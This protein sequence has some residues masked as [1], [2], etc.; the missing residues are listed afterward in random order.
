M[1]QLKV[2]FFGLICH[3]GKNR[4]KPQGDHAVLVNS[5]GHKP[6]LQWKHKNDKPNDPPRRACLEL[7]GKDIF[8]GSLRRRP[9]P[10]APSFQK[11]VVKLNDLILSGKSV[12]NNVRQQNN[13]DDVHAYIVYPAEADNLR[14]VLLYPNI[15]LHETDKGVP[16][17]RGCVA[18][19]TMTTFRTDKDEKEVCIG[20]VKNKKWVDLAKVPADGCVLFSNAEPRA[21]N[22]REVKVLAQ[23]NPHHVRL[24]SKITDDRIEVTA[25]NTE[26]CCDADSIP[27]K[28]PAGCEWVKKFADDRAIFASEY[29]DC[30]NGG[31]P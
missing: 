25:K 9:L 8:I 5:D 10:F 4:N 19:M 14:V 12:K 30:G 15:G 13:D 21:Q 18:R 31:D 26:I 27:I 20:Y 3:V 16:L 11:Y 7:E 29:V 6:L 1:P 28:F 22:L 23:M 17:R 2:F 24:Y